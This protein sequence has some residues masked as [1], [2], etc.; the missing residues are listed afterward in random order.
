MDCE[1]HLPTDEIYIKTAYNPK[2]IKN[3]IF[4]DID[5]S[6]Q[7]ATTNKAKNFLVHLGIRELTEQVDIM[8]DIDNKSDVNVDDVQMAILAVIDKY[9]KNEDIKVFAIVEGD[10]FD[11][12]IISNFQANKHLKWENENG[13]GS[14]EYKSDDFALDL[15]HLGSFFAIETI[16]AEDVKD[17]EYVTDLVET[18]R[19]FI[20]NYGEWF[21]SLY[22]ENKI[23]ELYKRGK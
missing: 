1:L 23:E 19:D 6:V 20:K 17:I 14:R 11:D 8:A 22:L 5:L 7:N 4:V 12:I 15:D 18:A 10:E 9:R 2:N 21:D 3:P 16:L 13:M